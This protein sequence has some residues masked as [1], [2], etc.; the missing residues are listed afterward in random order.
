MLKQPISSK[1]M[2]EAL[3]PLAASLRQ[4]QSSIRPVSQVILAL[5]VVDG[6]DIFAITRQSCLQWL[7][8]RAG[9]PLP[10][11]AWDGLSFELEEVGAQRVGAVGIEGPKY[12]S[13]RLDDADRTVAQRTWVTEIGIAQKP[14]G[15]V[16]FGSRL[17]CV[18]RGEDEPYERSIPSFV[19]PIAL[20]G[21]ATLDGR[22]VGSDPWLVKT[23]HDVDVL[24]GL[25]ADPSRD[26]DV[27][28]FSLPEDSTDPSETAAS[29][30]EVHRR[31]LGAAHIVVLTGPAG[32][33]LSDRVGR[34]FSVYR[35]GVR[36]YL[37]GFNPEQDQPFRHPL[38]LA[39][40]IAG[41]PN[42]GPDAYAKL[43]IS[44]ALARSVAKS[45]REERLPSFATISRYEAQ[46]ALERAQKSGSSDKDLLNL[47]LEEIGQLRKSLDDQKKTS[48][49]LLLTSQAECQVAQ[50][51]AQQSRF[52]ADNLRRRVESLEARLD[53]VGEQASA[54][55][56]PADLEDFEEWCDRYLTGFV[57][58]HNR[59]Y[60]GIKRSE[61][62]DHSFVY[63]SLL[64]LKNF[65]VPMRRHPGTDAKQKYD[66]ECK[67][68]GLQES[69]TISDERLGEQGDTYIVNYAGERRI[70]DRHLKRGISKD[71]RKCFRLYFF[72]DD[73]NEQVVVGWLPSHLDTRQS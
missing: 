37:P 36:T 9:R 59:A 13:A 41:W 71:R 23:K 68:L 61:Y 51:A 44:Q 25:L 73:E 69:G 3:K 33:Y 24:V 2:A 10:K 34:A 67:K 20:L 21:N 53:E 18:T 22:I 28:V 40:R 62:H 19:R 56:I 7:S 43:L 17:I 52:R 12:W 64:L 26:S 48:D 60:Q 57:E 66:D 29:A 47:A 27:I 58:L 55:P 4:K 32:F 45:D 72:W 63:Q 50:Q 15:Q 39:E 35:Q 70:L 11:S 1:P 5:E 30:R 6:K 31:T 8:S 38:G 46:L 42:G 65:Y 54:I 14:D 16:L 49:E